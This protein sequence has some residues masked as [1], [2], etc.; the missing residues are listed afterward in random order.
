M[1]GGGSVDTEDENIYTGVQGSPSSGNRGG[2]GLWVKKR[3]ELQAKFESLRDCRRT[4]YLTTTSNHN[5]KAFEKSPLDVRIEDLMCMQL[6]SIPQSKIS[7]Y[8]STALS[9]RKEVEKALKI[10]NNPEKEVQMKKFL[11]S[12]F[13]DRVDLEP[14]VNEIE[15][16]N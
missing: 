16:I 10:K 7:V 1:T 8:N 12:L 5:C 3:D 4:A 14:W 9:K 13:E 6:S 2:N 11:N 15:I